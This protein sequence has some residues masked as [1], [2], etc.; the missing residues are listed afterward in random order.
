M[1][2]L[3]GTGFPNTGA[4][5]TIGEQRTSTGLSTQIII[6]IGKT[7][8]GALQSLSVTQK[9]ALK[10]I[11]EIGTDGVIEIVPNQATEYD[12]S[13]TRIVFD[14]LRLP[15]AMSRGFRF[16]AAQRVPFDID[17]ID[18]TGT[19]ANVEVTDTNTDRVIMTYKNCWFTSY[20]TPYQAGEYIITEKADLQC[21]TAYLVQIGTD[22]TRRS[23]DY[24][25][26]N[27]GVEKEVNEGRRLGSLDASGL[28]NSL[29]EE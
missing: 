7:P 29:F 16:I 25:V 10:R 8:V 26:D 12:L 23:I 21:E 4:G 3:N 19:Q 11:T 1:A 20:E 17:V 9:R 6:K 14:Q 2:D 28:I 5:S 27:G 13:V 22:G 18:I 15:E 24:Q